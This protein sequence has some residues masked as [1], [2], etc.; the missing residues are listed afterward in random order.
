MCVGGIRRSTI[1]TS[2]VTASTGDQL[3]GRA[4]LADHVEAGLPEQ[5]R[6]ALAQQHRVVGQDYAH[7][8]SARSQCPRRRAPD[9][10]AP[11][12]RLDPVGEPTQAGAALG[13]GAAFAVVGDLDDSVPFSRAT[14]RSRWPPRRTWRRWSGPRPRGSRRRPR[15]APAAAP[16]GRRRAR[17]H[18]RAGGQRLERDRQP[19][20][21]QHGGVDALR[22]PRSSSSDAASSS[23]A[24]CSS[25]AYG[26]VGRHLA[27]DQPQH[28]R[29]RDEP[30]LSAVVQV[31]LELAARGVAGLDD[32]CPRGPQVA[33]PGAQVGLQALVLERDAGGGSD[34]ADQFGLVAQRRVVDERGDTASRRARRRSSHA[35][36]PRAGSS[37]GSPAGPTYASYSGTQ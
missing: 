2:G 36:S 21:A 28:D 31:A 3:L 14:P 19:V 30:L 16:R 29:E 13:V 1:A 25:S 37:T 34:G 12:E 9:P 6:D 24:V 33:E 7:G 4:G 35:G 15:P 26:L 11:V 8:I 17:P 23:R 27:G 20:V 18:R 32:P 5:Q 22:D 10:Q